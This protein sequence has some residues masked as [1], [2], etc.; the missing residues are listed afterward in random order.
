M[1][2]LVSPSESGPSL[3][4]GGPEWR[5]PKTPAIASSNA[6]TAIALDLENKFLPRLVMVPRPAET[7]AVFPIR[8][9]VMAGFILRHCIAEPASADSAKEPPQPAEGRPTVLEWFLWCI[10]KEALS[11]KFADE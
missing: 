4:T 1:S 11:G 3:S 6:A 8:D 9:S 7:H 10:P 5:H 2:E